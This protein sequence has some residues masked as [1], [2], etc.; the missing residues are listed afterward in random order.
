MNPDVLFSELRNAG[1]DDGR[2]WAAEA[3]RL[4]EAVTGSLAGSKLDYLVGRVLALAG[5]RKDLRILDFGCGSGKLVIF[6]RML[7]FT[8]VRGVDVHADGEAVSRVLATRLGL[9]PDIFATYDT[10]TLPY[11][12]ASFDLIVSE[13]VLEHVHN[14]DDYY[15]EAARVLRPGGS[16]LLLFPH[17]MMPFDSHSRTWFVHYLPASLRRVLYDRLTSQ[18]GDYFARILNLRGLSTHRAVALRHFSA[19]ALNTA[20]RLRKAGYTAHYEGNRGLREAAQRILETPML[21]SLACWVFSRLAE[22]EILL[23]K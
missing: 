15:R 2:D 7:G 20:T 1:S 21:G 22:A 10:V 4:Q 11:A 17:R 18:G 12:D 13:E 6:L 23:V 19:Y 16:A 3:R 5:G 9:P 8:D 14:L